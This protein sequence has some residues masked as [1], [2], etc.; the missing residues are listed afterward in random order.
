MTKREHLKARFHELVVKEALGTASDSERSKLDRM[1]ALLRCRRTP[2][3]VAWESRVQFHHSQA[4]RLSR[5]IV[6]HRQVPSAKLKMSLHFMEQ[7][8][9]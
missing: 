4:L 5:C 6:T 1:Q 8:L 9:K 2:E 7:V 3:Q